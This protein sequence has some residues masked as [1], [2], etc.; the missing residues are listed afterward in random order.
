MIITPLVQIKMRGGNTN[1][2]FHDRIWNCDIEIVFQ[3]DT[4]GQ[5]LAVCDTLLSVNRLPADEHAILRNDGLWFSVLPAEAWRHTKATQEELDAL[6]FRPLIHP[7]MDGYISDV[8][9]TYRIGEARGVFY[10]W[11]RTRG[12]AKSAGGCVWFPVTDYNEWKAWH[13]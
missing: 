7:K 11:H 4:S 1:C 13:E 12:R 5:L 9:I 3:E 10:H 6:G 2:F 8:E